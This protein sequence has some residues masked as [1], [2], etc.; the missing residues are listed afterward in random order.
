MIALIV[1]DIAI[2]LISL[3]GTMAALISMAGQ[4]GEARASTS[5]IAESTERIARIQEGLWLQLR[6]QYADIDRDLQEIKD[7]LHGDV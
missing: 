6:R 4:L 1:L 2:G 7:L 3:G 5:R